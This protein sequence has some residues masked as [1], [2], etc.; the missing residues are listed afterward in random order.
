MKP[1]YL[2]MDNVKVRNANQSCDL[3][4]IVKILIV[5]IL[6][7]KYPN[8]QNCHIYTE[9]SYESPNEYYPDIELWLKEKHNKPFR[10][11]IIEIQDK[12]SK[13]WIK[14]MNE[15]YTD[16]DWIIIPLKEVEEEWKEALSNKKI[17]PI[18]VLGKI[19]GVYL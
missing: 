17:N 3:H 10:R 13:K 19:L 8:K 9:Y 2:K 7:R 14:K 5:R 15:R 1:N 11:T 18:Q 6:R 12:V 16:I 4:D